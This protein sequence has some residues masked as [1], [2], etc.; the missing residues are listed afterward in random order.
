VGVLVEMINVDEENVASRGT[1][2]QAVGHEYSSA[3]PEN[4]MMG[5]LGTDEQI[6]EAFSSKKPR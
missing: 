6:S 1:P 5:S 2:N 4:F 3:G